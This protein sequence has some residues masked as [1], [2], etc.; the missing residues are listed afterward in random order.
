MGL[1]SDANDTKSRIRIKGCRRRTDWI[2]L[3]SKYLSRFFAIKFTIDPT[4]R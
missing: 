3:L 2:R 4:Q 1:I